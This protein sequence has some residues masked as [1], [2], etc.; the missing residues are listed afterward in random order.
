[1][2]RPMQNGRN[3][4]KWIRRGKFINEPFAYLLKI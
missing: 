3:N 1:L 2:N 4:R